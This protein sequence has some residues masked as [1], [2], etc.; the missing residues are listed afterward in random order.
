MTDQKQPNRRYEITKYDGREMTVESVGIEELRAIDPRSYDHYMSTVDGT[1]GYK[2]ASGHWHEYR[3][4]W[5]GLGKETLN[6]LRALQLNAGDFLTPAE[7]MELT[8]NPFLRENGNVA[9]RVAAIRNQTHADAPGR[10][11]ET[12][13]AGGYAVRWCP[14]R[15]WLWIDRAPVDGP[16]S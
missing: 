7:L 13:R 11:I 12:R 1:M 16:Q 3:G 5:P 14:D 10:F 2:D 4:Q 15:T 6:L 8:D 9:A